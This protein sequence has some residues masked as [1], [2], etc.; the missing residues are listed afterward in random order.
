MVQF[1]D[2]FADWQ[3]LPFDEDAADKFKEFRRCKIRISSTDL[4]IAAIA[5][6]HDATLLSRNLD[7][8]TRIPELRVENWLTVTRDVEA[9]G[10]Q[11]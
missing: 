4:K 9:D 10:E 6:V 3:L 5:L 2:F 1:A 7:D 11:N 8:F